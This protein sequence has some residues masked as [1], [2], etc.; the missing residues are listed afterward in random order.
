[1]AEV[2]GGF[3]PSLLGTN[4][5]LFRIVTADLN[6]TADQILTPLFAFS[7]YV[8]D[9]IV[10]AD[11]SGPVTAATGALYTRT[12]KSGVPLTSSAQSLAGLDNTA[13]VLNPPLTAAATGV[14]TDANVYLSL[15]TP[16]G[17]PKTCSAFVMGI[18]G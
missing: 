16:E 5:T 10:F 14:I 3:P 4:T 7:R 8:I 11:P 6:S 12:S 17:S 2:A 18:A 9:K 15:T 1:M 13:A